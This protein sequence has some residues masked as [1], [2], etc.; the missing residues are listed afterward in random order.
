MTGMTVPAPTIQ[1]PVFIFGCTFFRLMVP[2]LAPRSL[3][4]LAVSKLAR[5]FGFSALFIEGVDHDNRKRPCSFPDAIM[6]LSIRH[7]SVIA[8]RS[9]G[10]SPKVS[11]VPPAI[12]STSVDRHSGRLVSLAR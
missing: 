5:I 12:K 6:R 9:M 10:F 8:N 1:L 11:Q 2:C 4:R 3:C 7:G